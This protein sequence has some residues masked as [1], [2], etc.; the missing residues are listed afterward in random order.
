MLE[1]GERQGERLDPIE[2]VI[3]TSKLVMGET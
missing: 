2:F 1:I 3:S